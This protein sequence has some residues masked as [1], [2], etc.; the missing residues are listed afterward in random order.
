[1]MMRDLAKLDRDPT[2]T[3]RAAATG[4]TV[5]GGHRQA[6]MEPLPPQPQAPQPARPHELPGPRGA[7]RPG[8]D[9]PAEARE[10]FADDNLRESRMVELQSEGASPLSKDPGSSQRSW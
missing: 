7:C 10:A 9:R 8:R 2:G 5:S 6:G 4:A 1:M 3:F